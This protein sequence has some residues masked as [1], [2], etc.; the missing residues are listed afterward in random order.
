MRGGGC[1]IVYAVVVKIVVVWTHS[2]T[3]ARHDAGCKGA[4]FFAKITKG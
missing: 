3:A 2:A 4:P 1:C